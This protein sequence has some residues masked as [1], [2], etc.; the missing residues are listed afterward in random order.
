MHR[1]NTNKQ[2]VR[3]VF[4]MRS[5]LAGEGEQLLLESFPVIIRDD[6]CA[7]FIELFIAVQVAYGLAVG[8]SFFVST[9]TPAFSKVNSSGNMAY[10]KTMESCICTCPANQAPERS[11][12]RLQWQL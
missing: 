11:G 12:I 7:M 2:P 3:A 8:K 10:R 6:H 4:I 1:D 9:Q 5:I